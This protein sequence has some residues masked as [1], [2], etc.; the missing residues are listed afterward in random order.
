MSWLRWAD[1]LR[2]NPEQAVTDLLRGAAE[3]GTFERATP[4]DFLL[5]VLPRNSRIVAAP[6]LGEPSSSLAMQDAVIDL[7]ERLDAGLSAWFGR[8]RNARTLHAMKISGYSAQVSE[9]LQWPLYFALPQ[10]RATLQAERAQWLKWLSSL[11]LSAYRD[12]EYDY[13]QMLAA[14]QPDDKLQFFWQ[15]FVVEASRTY[16]DRYLNLGLLALAKLPLDEQDSLRNLRLQVQALVNRYERRRSLGTLAQEELAQALRGVMVRNPSLSA[17]NYRAFLKE[18]LFKLGEDKVASILSILGLSNVPTTRYVSSSSGAAYKLNRTLSPE[19]TDEAVQAVR[20]STSLMQAWKA[21]FGLINAQEDFMRKSGD[22]YNFVR[23]LDRCARALCDRFAIREPE[24]ERR[25][26]QWIHLALRME[27]DEPRRWMLWEL[28]LRKS[29]HPERAQ[30]VLWEMTRRFPENVFCRVELAR[31]LSHSKDAG[32]QKHADRL[33]LQ[34]LQLDADNLPAHSTLAQLAIRRQDWPV[35]LHHAQEGLRIDPDDARSAVLLATAYSWRRESGDLQLAIDHLQRFV[36]RHPHEMRTEDYLRTLIRRQEMAA[37][38]K[39]AV[40]ED[41]EQPTVIQS[42]RSEEDFAWID[43]AESIRA[44]IASGASNDSQKF[45]VLEGNSSDKVLPLPDALRQAAIE[46]QWGADLLDRYPSSIRQEF[47]LET[48]L[49]RYLQS[50]QSNFSPENQREHAKRALQAWLDD[51]N[52]EHAGNEVWL[53]Y[54]HKHW[55]KLVSSPIDAL[56]FGSKWL[57]EL[58]DRYHPLPMP[59]M[60]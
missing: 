34:V 29:G 26:F 24:I 28:A 23:T 5:A 54:L 46:G 38:G 8:Q 33:L 40:F 48:L 14:H 45:S 1:E 58:V 41:E 30:W 60:A 15:T 51:Q 7:T 18:L 9:A 31:L 32:D 50:L 16:S 10:T 37:Q 17:S 19:V 4:H 53:N 21:I 12:P 42:Q 57:V 3:I 6:L 39:Q 2:R 11:T 13:W 25:L 49:W 59:L 43:F 52:R 44:W 27:I 20:R 55:H 22:A 36:V 47:P 56:T 35:A